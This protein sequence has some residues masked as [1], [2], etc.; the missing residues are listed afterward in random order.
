M[1]FIPEGLV[2]VASRQAL[3]GAQ[4][5]PQLLFAGGVVGVVGTTVLACRATLKL[6]TTL[7]KHRNDI[8]IL[9]AMEIDEDNAYGANEFKKD[10]TIVYVKSVTDVVKLYAPAVIIGGLSI[11][12][13]TKSHTLLTQ[14]NAALMSAYVA[15]E[16]G[17][18]EYRERVVERYG[19]DVDRQ[20]MFP[21]EKV[22]EKNEA[23][24][25]N[26]TVEVLTGDS[27][28]PYARLFDPTCR[29]WS[30]APEYNLEFLRCQQNYANERLRAFGHL[31][32]NEVYDML[33]LERS[34]AGQVV[35]WIYEGDGDGYVDF[36]V[37]NGED[38]AKEFINGRESSVMLDFNVDGL[39]YNQLGKYSG[40]TKAHGNV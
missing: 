9:R 24:G 23:T 21:R 39:I 7:D 28:S 3:L 29:M 8:E 5:S 31:F 20:L 11:A 16:K 12:A 40:R 30:P 37:L 14:R 18:K 17:Y 13:L 2:R 38:E 19:E 22:T 35:G 4:H 25:R 1:K 10:T 6:E 32:L 36:G 15:V 34:E 33:G 26:H 27:A